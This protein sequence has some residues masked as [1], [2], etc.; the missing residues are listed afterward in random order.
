MLNIESHSVLWNED[1][2]AD[3]AAKHFIALFLYLMYLFIY[4]RQGLA[5]Q[6]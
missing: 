5:V 3:L 6:F 1:S 2:D 4:L